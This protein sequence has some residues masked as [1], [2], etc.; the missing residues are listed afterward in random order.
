MVALV[1]NFI[2]R[3]D[4]EDL[5]LAVRFIIGELFPP[6]EPEVGLG[7]SGV[8]EC[9]VKAFSSSKKEFFE[10]FKSTGDLGLA[11]MKIA[12]RRLRG[13]ALAM[14]GYLRVREVYEAFKCLSLKATSFKCLRGRT[15]L[16]KALGG[17]AERHASV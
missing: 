2:K 12:E 10:A 13:P 5:E 6:W 11:S 4:A 14:G 1:S 7:A 17:D 9:V 8:V 16:K 15:H 3:L